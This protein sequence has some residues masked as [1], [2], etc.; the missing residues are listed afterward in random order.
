MD[1]HAAGLKDKHA[2]TEQ[3]VC[4]PWTNAAPPSEKLSDRGW[5]AEHVGW[6][7]DPLCSDD[8]I[9][10]SFEITV[11]DLSKQ[12]CTEM[13][14]R[15]DLL[16]LAGGSQLLIVNYFGA[17]RFGSARHGQG[18][19]AE[20]LIRGDFE[21][22]LKLMI[23]TPTR[24]DTGKTRAVTRAC[25]E[26]WGQ[27][28]SAL[29]QMPRCP[30][31]RAIEVLAAGGS[32]KDAFVELPY[33]DQQM[34]VEAYQSYLWN[35]IAVHAIDDLLKTEAS[36]QSNAARPAARPIR[37]DDEFGV[38]LFAPAAAVAPELLEVRIPLLAPKSELVG[39]WAQAAAQVLADEKLAVADL[40]IPGI[41]RPYFGEALRPWFVTAENVEMAA[42]EADD[43]A[44]GSRLKRVIRF[45]LPR[46]A[47]AT[48]VLRALGQ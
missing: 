35:A 21:T 48:V 44:K 43:L 15:A 40:K 8:I 12:Q 22:A 11:R 42:P 27:W 18:F 16:K 36:E 20:H 34:S 37:A 19:V 6:A 46:G 17:Q 26:H 9:G 31:R 41:R 32:F 1:V 24:K 5:S 7:S 29:K 23:G 47:Y 25:A 3:W 14:R 30:Q 10:N 38:M 45:D 2:Q 4:A 39:P 28:G 13:N 33:F